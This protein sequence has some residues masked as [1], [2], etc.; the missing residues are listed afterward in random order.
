MR[1]SPP[2]RSHSSTYL[3]PAFTL[4]SCN[5]HVFP[6]A[7][8]NLKTPPPSGKGQDTM[9]LSPVLT[10][11]EIKA[12]S[13]AD[14][15]LANAGVVY[16]YARDSKRPKAPEAI[17]MSFD[18]CLRLKLKLDELE[19][20]VKAEPSMSNLAVILNCEYQLYKLYEPTP[21]RYH[22][23]LSHWVEA[24]QKLQSKWANVAL[25][26]GAG[27]GAGAGAVAT[28]GNDALLDYRLVHKT[29]CLVIFEYLLNGN[30]GSS[31]ATKTPRS[32]CET[33]PSSDY[34]LDVEPFIT[35]LEEEGIYDKPVSA[36]L[37]SIPP[38]LPS[39]SPEKLEST[40]RGISRDRSSKL[41]LWKEKLLELL[42]TSP[43]SAVEKLTH[44]PIEL[45]F[46]DFL[47][48]LLQEN[49]LQNT[50][51]EPFPV[52]HDFI[53]HSLR[54]IE[55]MGESSSNTSPEPSIS[56]PT[57]GLANGD[58]PEEFASETPHGRDAQARAVKLL[59]LFIRNLVRKGLLS[60]GDIYFEISE[61]CV[62]YVWIKEV[63]EFS[64]FVQEGE[65]D[66]V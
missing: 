21:V 10:A 50:S 63:R 56:A 12:F 45:P 43:E 1:G 53:Q 41:N 47:T 23:F 18:E 6:A 52:V 54:L 36:G 13:D 64:N 32:L 28:G 17:G 42:E 20:R 3:P 9:E 30:R 40:S 57:L 44:L 24:I 22:P 65:Q 58:V 31:L 27:A 5:A 2:T 33:L 7:A 51:I 46:L 35:M 8:A 61:I 38:S 34:E 29:R 11:K 62:R 55:E 14:R 66:A 19:G 16:Q 26:G 60:P 4:A 15:T 37:L 49:M 39:P 59:L 48:T 25:E